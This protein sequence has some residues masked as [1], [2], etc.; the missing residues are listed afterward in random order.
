MEPSETTSYRFDRF[1]VDARSACLRRDGTLVP[2]RPK[3]FD[4]L[5]YLVRNRGRLVS[6]SDLIDKIWSNVIVTDNSLV[7]CIKE[8]RQALGDDRQTTIET[9]AK[10]GYVFA[11]D[12]VEIS[13]VEPPAAALPASVEGSSSSGPVPV[14]APSRRSPW[15][16]LAAV[17]GIAVVILGGFWWAV[18]RQIPTTVELPSGIS[19]SYELN[20]LPSVVVQPFS[21]I[22]GDQL[23]TLLARGFT[24]RLITDLSRFSDIRVVS[25]RIAGASVEGA[26]VE[27]EPVKK[28]AAGNY[29]VA[30]EVQRNGDSIRVYIHLTEA[31]SGRSLWSEQYDRPYTDIFA[32]QDDLTR[33]VLGVL[34]VKVTDAELLR[35]ARPYTRNLEAYEHFL[36]AQSALIVRSNAENEVARQLYSEAIRLDPSFARAYAGLALTYAADRRNRWKLDGAAALAKAFELARTAQRIDPDIAETYFALAYVNMERGAFPEAVDELRTA[37]RLS[38]SF[39][40]AYSLM[41]AIQTYRGQPSETIPLMR[42]AMRL[43]PDAGHLYFLILGRAYFFLGDATSALLYLR[44]AI[45]RNPESLEIRIFL[46]AALVL[47]GQRDEAAWQVDEIRTLEPAF[48]IREWLKS[49][50]MSDAKQIKQLIDAA[51]TLGL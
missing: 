4:V 37:V 36:R 18:P 32:L 16:V 28:T 39:A 41:G 12:V 5:L 31:V 19:N 30:G 34:R 50:P 38:P 35:R 9:V 27:G 10:R 24:A 14:S 43:V 48:S 47:A 1:T 13:D 29:V 2:L 23:Q 26:S 3:S 44:Q 25:F 8:I 42:V 45:A 22:E 7:Q 21:E 51:G 20:G 17:S 6:K 49:Y 46:A 33:Q 11:P 15:L 40:D